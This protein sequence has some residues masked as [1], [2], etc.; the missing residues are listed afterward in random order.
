LPCGPKGGFELVA[1]KVF[2]LLSKKIIISHSQDS[3]IYKPRTRDELVQSNK[4]FYCFVVV[5]VVS[6]ENYHFN[7]A[8]DIFAI[9]GEGHSE[10]KG[11]KD[12]ENIK[13]TNGG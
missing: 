3:I 2:K 11:K 4:L 5:V 6:T 1:G 8:N 7:L 10:Q 9:R 12:G 13:I